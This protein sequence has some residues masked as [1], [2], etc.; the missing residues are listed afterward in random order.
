M[1]IR[2]VE[3]LVAVWDGGAQNEP[4]HSRLGRVLERLMPDAPLTDDTLGRRNQ[5]LIALHGEI[6]GGAIEAVAACPACA[7]ENEFDVP[8]TAIAE[9]SVPP[10]GGHVAAGGLRARVPVMA[11]LA[12]IAGLPPEMAARTLLRRCLDGAPLTID[13]VTLAALGAAFEQADPA[14]VVRLASACA[15]CGAT[16]TVEVDIAAF[17]A[18]AVERKVAAQLMQ[19]AVLARAFGWSES[20]ILALPAAR[21]VRYMMMIEGGR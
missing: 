20:E 9:A 4:P 6:V 17:V 12:A 5:R 1:Q 16:M 14:A 18:G 15:Q 10:V 3:Q 2:A 11:D 13:D 8:I 7:T 21:R 19:V